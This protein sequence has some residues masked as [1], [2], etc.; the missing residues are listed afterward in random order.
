MPIVNKKYKGILFATN[1]NKYCEQHAFA[2]NQRGSKAP[3]PCK[4]CGRGTNSTT[5]LCKYC[6]QNKILLKLWRAELKMKVN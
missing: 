5:H 1:K 6:E 2:I 4:E 3:T